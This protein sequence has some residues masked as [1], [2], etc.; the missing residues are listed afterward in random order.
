MGNL[1]ERLA[2]NTVFTIRIRGREFDSIRGAFRFISPVWGPARRI[3]DNLC[4]QT[5][6]GGLAG[7]LGKESNYL[8]PPIS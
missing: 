2:V 4:F 7:A 3:V 1:G 6:T 5:S 8:Q